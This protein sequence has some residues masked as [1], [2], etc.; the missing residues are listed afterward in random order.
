MSQ[1]RFVEPVELDR[2]RQVHLI[3][4]LLDVLGSDSPLLSMPCQE[5]KDFEW[6]VL[7]PSCVVS[8]LFLSV[9]DP[10]CSSY[11]F[12]PLRH[13]QPFYRRVFETLLYNFL[14]CLHWNVYAFRNVWL[15]DERNNFEK[16]GFLNYWHY[17]TAIFFISGKMM[18]PCSVSIKICL[19]AW[20]CT[21]T[22]RGYQNCLVR[23]VE[24][25][26]IDD[27]GLVRNLLNDFSWFLALK[28]SS[29]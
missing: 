25:H 29:R 23:R 28:K 22:V 9:S 24:K 21:T 18:A 27:F 26:K 19:E 10:V 16:N 14:L 3:T 17:L 15:L 12:P 11:L 6:V 20:N 5:M 13:M 2:P 4:S 1:S 7:P 8:A